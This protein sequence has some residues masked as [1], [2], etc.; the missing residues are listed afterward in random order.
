MIRDGRYYRHKGYPNFEEYCLSRWGFTRAQ[1]DRLIAAWPLALDLTP[2]GVKIGAAPNE[3]QVRELLPLAKSDLGTRP[4]V[5]VYTAVVEHLAETPDSERERVTA[6]LLKDIVATLPV[7]LDQWQ[8]DTVEQHVRAVL[9][10][11][12]SRAGG[13]TRTWEQEAVRLRRTLAH[14]GKLDVAKVPADDALSL[15]E[16][17]RATADRL[18][19]AATSA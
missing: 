12:V 10:G 19:Q 14:L 18:T 11:E 7:T 3:S 8:R 4:A 15:A 13:G 5:D 1:A 16:E 2:I 6:K 9:D 17:L